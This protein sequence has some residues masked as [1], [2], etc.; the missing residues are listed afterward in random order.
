MSELNK[1]GAAGAVN[2]VGAAIVRELALVIA[3]AETDNYTGGEAGAGE[4]ADEVAGHGVEGDLVET[5]LV[6][7]GD[8]ARGSRGVRAED[9]ASADNETGL[10]AYYRAE[11]GEVVGASARLDA[12][13]NRI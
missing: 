9:G 2:L 1:D 6:P 4:L 5:G 3:A 12:G 13:L 7:Q 8:L 10:A 11:H